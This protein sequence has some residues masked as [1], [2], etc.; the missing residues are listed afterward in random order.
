[1]KKLLLTFALA[2]A[3]TLPLTN[4]YA[5]NPA[6]T[7]ALTICNKINSCDSNTNYSECKS[8][9]VYNN[10]I[11]GQL[12]DELTSPS[13]EEG[14]YNAFNIDQMVQVGYSTYNTAD[15][16]RCISQIEAL[17]CKSINAGI[18]Y[19]GTD[20]YTNTEEIFD[21]GLLNSC[22]GLFQHKAGVVHGTL[23]QGTVNPPTPPLVDKKK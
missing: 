9:L 17:S 18:P 5:A 6:T 23:G 22:L 1:M 14:V 19:T 10:P 15:Y 16:D 13:V 2:G 8:S 20:A 7:I 21:T 11:S 3:L 4:L 12:W